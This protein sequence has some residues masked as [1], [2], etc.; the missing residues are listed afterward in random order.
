MDPAATLQAFATALQTIA[1]Q[2]PLLRQ[3]HAQNEWFLP[4]LVRHAIQK[5]LPWFASENARRF[6][7][8]SPQARRIGIVMAGNLPLVGLHDLL[9]CLL[10]GHF[11]QVKP[12]SKDRVLLPALVQSLPPAIQDRI[13]IHQNLSPEDI[14]F[15]LATG[16]DNTAR[17]LDHDFAATPRLI[18]KNRFSVAVLQG[19]EEAG[20]LDGLARDILL[21]HGMGCRSVSNLLVPPDWDPKPLAEALQRFPAAW[22]SPA[23][24]RIVRWENAVQ[25]MDSS[26]PP[27]SPR[28]AIRWSKGIGTAP[29]GTLKLVPDQGQGMEKLK[30]L[31]MQIQCLVGRGQKVRFGE[32]QSP[33]LLDFAD[34]VDTWKLLTGASGEELV[35]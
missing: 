17:Y 26:Q 24:E 35:G 28:L 6:H 27:L 25:S 9:I 22:L 34:G 12:S 18:R 7:P 13:R 33:G 32:T 15:L 1:R 19:D 4:P 20:E 16:S 10:A 3:A 11:P 14:D 23:W 31:D 5:M 30:G 2:E 21:Y 29:V 8:P